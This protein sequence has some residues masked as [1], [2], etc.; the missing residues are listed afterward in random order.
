[1]VIS[2]GVDLVELDRVQRLVERH[3][4]RALARV[5]TRAEMEYCRGRVPELAARFAAKEAVSKAL[6]VGLRI[7]ARDGARRVVERPVDWGL[8]APAIEVD[9]GHLEVLSILVLQ[10]LPYELARLCERKR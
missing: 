9:L 5:Y 1:M 8:L 4:E 7:M 2:T 10:F 3:G 6:G